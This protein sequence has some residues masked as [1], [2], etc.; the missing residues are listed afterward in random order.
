MGLLHVIHTSLACRPGHGK[1]TSRRAGFSLLEVSIS[2]LVIAIFISSILTTVISGYAVLDRSRETLRA[3]QII[4]QELETL[5]TYSWS[6]V[7]NAANFYTTNYADQGNSY[8][9]TRMLTNYNN[10]TSYSTNY[11]RKVTVSVVWT[12]GPGKTITK[13]M[14]TLISQG[15]L[16]DYIY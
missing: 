6:Q 13:D 3:N 4:Q 15:G 2:S 14:T 10:S 1:R 12:N 9:V 16:N 5:R 7:T 8:K 11:M